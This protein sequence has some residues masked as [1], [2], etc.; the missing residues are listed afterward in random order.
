M[1][2]LGLCSSCGLNGGLCAV[3]MRHAVYVLPRANCEQAPVCVGEQDPFLEEKRHGGR[4]RQ[5]VPA[6]RAASCLH[7]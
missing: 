3:G 2:A 7:R 5:R 1:E 4:V 6:L